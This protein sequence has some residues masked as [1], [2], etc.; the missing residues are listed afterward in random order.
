[1]KKE[2][3]QM[4]GF[5]FYVFLN[6]IVSSDVSRFIGVSHNL[7]HVSN[8]CVL[9]RHNVLQVDIRVHDDMGKDHAVFHDSPLLDD[10][11][12]ANDR[13]LDGPLDEAAV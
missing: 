7:F 3:R 8:F 12:A 9:V 4:T 13:V 1:M 11:S 6:D 2:A 5:F 10:A